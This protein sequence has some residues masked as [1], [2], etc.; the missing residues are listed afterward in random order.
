L[1]NVLRP[2]LIIDQESF[3]HMAEP[4]PFIN[5]AVDF[6]RGQG[7][8]W[9]AKA[10]EAL[11]EAAATSWGRALLRNSPEFSRICNQLTIGDIPSQERVRLV[12]DLEAQHT[13][14]GIINRTRRRDI[15][16]FTLRKPE[17]V[18][19]EFT[20]AQKKLHDD[21][22][23]IQAKIFS[24]IH[25]DTNVKFMMTTIRRQAASC[26]FG[27]VPF[28]QEILNRHV[29]ELAWEEADNTGEAPSATTVE[30][31]ETRIKT[32]LEQARNLDRED[33]KLEALRKILRNKQEMP[34]NKV[35]LF[36]SFRHTLHYL[37]QHLKADGFRVGLVHG[38]VLDEERAEMR[39]R[40][41]LKQE[42]EHALDLMLFS[43]IGSEGLDYQFCDCIVN[44]DL[45][46]NPMRI[47][48]RIGRIDR[49]GQQSESVAIFNLITP[50]TVDADIYERCLVRIG[51]FNNALGGSED[52]LGEISREIRNIAEN[53]N[54]SDDERREKLQQLA[55]NQ[56]RLIQE[57]EE[58]EQKQVELFGI[59]LPEDQM[60]KEINEASS[61]WLSPEAIR[62]LITNYLQETF[63]K[64]QEFI[65]G[66]KPLKT[67]RLSLE[68][69][70]RLLKDF[71]KLPRQN[72]SSYREW[73]NW[74]KGGNPHLT[75]TFD[76]ACASQHPDAAFIMP[77]HPLVRQA[78]R[79]FDTTKRVVTTL[80]V[81]DQ[82]VPYGDYPFAIYQWQF[83]GIRED[84]VLCPVASSERVTSHLG[85]LL[86]KAEE[87]T[88][89]EANVP[90]PLAWDELDAQ[91][92]KLWSEAREK[93][94]RRT[95]ELAQYRRESLTTSHCARIALLKDQLNQATDEKIRRMRQSQI[96]SAEADY[97]R[98]IQ[99]L[100]IAME[101]A[102]ITAQPVAYGV[103]NI[104]EV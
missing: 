62:N 60:K 47:E 29:D 74:L 46:W 37:H 45:P 34:N 57:Q 80:K 27:L 101:R 56:I 59:R 89:S 44:Y 98:R 11:D 97:A 33:P 93:H 31:I 66:E 69:R 58:L 3:E 9:S 63:G 18:V 4:N 88:T 76:A 19:I 68:V 103:I 91:H 54:L 67:L 7:T 30:A 24:Q 82:S 8:G 14:S 100:D 77:L 2:D 36:S 52:I 32:I 81:K 64:E 28:L 72:T 39:S 86:E 85:K 20:P 43:E 22:L 102:D 104:E 42:D 90:E 55:D 95:Q 79:A 49:W 83:H 75:F 38:G 40:F 35:M 92:Y 23:Q 1:L 26:L 48:Q 53:F 96:D 78:S 17:T 25:G 41:E 99:E 5:R 13:F 84:L 51:V 16:E 65:L 61:F 73:E 10:A 15:G 12:T 6:A 94:Q 87:N 50:G 21:L 70:N 71:Q